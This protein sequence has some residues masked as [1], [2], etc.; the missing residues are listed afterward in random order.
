MNEISFRDTFDPK[1]TSEGKTIAIIEETE[2]GAREAGT[3]AGSARPYPV[4]AGCLTE[5]RRPSAIELEAL[6]ARIGR[7]LGTDGP[8]RRR[9]RL[10]AA[11]SIEGRHGQSDGDRPLVVRGH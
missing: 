4:L 9:A 5:G 1:P 7:E 11:A 8:P 10:V 3:E 6:A 2:S